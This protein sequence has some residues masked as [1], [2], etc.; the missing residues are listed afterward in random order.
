MS[1]ILFVG[2][3]PNPEDKY[4]NIFFRNLIF[5]M[6]DMGIECTVISP[7]SYMHYGKRIKNIPRFV[8]VSYTHLTLPTNSRV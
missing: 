4:K 7:V 1:K 3:Y 6:A 5:A 2:W 8:A